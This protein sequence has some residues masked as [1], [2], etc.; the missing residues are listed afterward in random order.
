[1]WNY[2]EE[3]NW[4]ERSQESRGYESAKRYI[5]ENFT[6]KRIKEIDDFVRDRHNELYKRIEEFERANDT[7][8]GNYGGDDSFGDMINHA[9]G[10]GEEY[11]NS[12]MENPMLLNDLDYVESFSYC[13]PFEDEY[14]MLKGEYHQERA[15]RALIELANILKDNTPSKEDVKI[16]AE[17]TK[18][19]ADMVAGNFKAAT[20]GFNRKKYSEY[21]QFE[22]NDHAAMF[23]NIL[24]DCKKYM[25]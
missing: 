6:P 9:V 22:A 2:V 13:I 8:C 19:M 1:M 17:I 4:A 3:I 21:Y 18:R 25:V 15:V 24:G 12:V 5:L 10:L 11:F 16:V 23:S 14:E 20:K 7:H